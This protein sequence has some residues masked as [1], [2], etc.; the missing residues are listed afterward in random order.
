VD[1]E[2]SG[3]TKNHCVHHIAAIVAELSSEKILTVVSTFDEHA[4]NFSTDII[5]PQA[6]RISG[7][8]MKTL[9]SYPD[10][11]Q[12]FKN[13]KAF[14]SRVSGKNKMFFAGWNAKFDE[15]MI[16][17]LFDK[18]GE[19]KLYN[20]L[21]W[22]PSLDVMVLTLDVVKDSRHTFE[23]FKLT[24]VAKYFGVNQ[25]KKFHNAMVDVDSTMKIHSFA[26]GYLIENNKKER[27]AK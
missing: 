16:R 7:I 24:T 19:S 20:Q 8:D 22:T 23:N 1:T 15:E 17:G 25:D 4:M 2:T 18:N 26:K 21:F 27:R 13:F 11:R 12:T 10:P 3:L 14:L 5:D 6:M 9:A